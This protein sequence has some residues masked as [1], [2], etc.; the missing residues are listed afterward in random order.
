ME[1]K[2]DKDNEIMY[3]SIAL[4]DAWMSKMNEDKKEKLILSFL[5]DGNVKE[6]IDAEKDNVGITLG[7]KLICLGKEYNKIKLSAVDDNGE[8]TT[9][10]E[11]DIE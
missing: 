9:L 11:L 5:K 8:K 7:N 10:G 2:K 6:E 1:H 4:C 3:N